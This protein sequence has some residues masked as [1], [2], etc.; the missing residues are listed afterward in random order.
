MATELSLDDNATNFLF[1]ETSID[2]IPFKS[3]M[4]DAVFKILTP[5][6]LTPSFNKE[7]PSEFDNDAAT[8]SVL[9]LRNLILE[10][11]RFLSKSVFL[12]TKFPSLTDATSKELEVIYDKRIPLG[13]KC[14]SLTSLPVS[15]S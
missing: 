15:I 2:V 11:T 6:E 12:A 10:R 3:N 8:N 13:A 4:K 14:K 5:L 1:G 7:T 9:S